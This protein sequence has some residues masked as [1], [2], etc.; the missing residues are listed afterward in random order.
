MEI[1]WQYAPMLEMTTPTSEGLPNRVGPK[2][3]EIG[4]GRSGGTSIGRG[5]TPAGVTPSGL[6]D[7]SYGSQWPIEVRDWAGRPLLIKV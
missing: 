4:G 7:R 5:V 3:G 6:V 2:P 1:V